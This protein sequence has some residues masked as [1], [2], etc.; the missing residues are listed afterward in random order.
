M[1]RENKIRTGIFVLTLN[2]KLGFLDGKANKNRGRARVC[3]QS[4]SSV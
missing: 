3:A 2:L 4:L 1:G